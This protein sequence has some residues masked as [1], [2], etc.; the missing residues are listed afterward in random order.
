M[1]STTTTTM[2]ALRQHRQYEPLVVEEVAIPTAEPGSAV[3]EVL[4]AGVISYTRDVYDG[5]RKYPYVTPLT[6]GSSAIGRIHAVGPDSTKLQK[7]QLVL[8][9]IT[10]RSRDDSSHVFLSAIISGFTEGSRKLMQHWADGTYAE[11]VKAPLEN[12]FALDEARLMG[13][14]GYK[15]PDLL[16]MTRLL[17]PWG[18]LID[19]NLAPGETVVV[20]PATGSFG[21]GAVQLALAM[22]AR[23]IAMG[24]NARVLAQLREK[25]SEQYPADRL[26]TVPITGN[27]EEEM[28]A[29]KAAAGTRPIDA[30]YDISPDAATNATYFKAAIMSLRHSGRIS[31]MGG[32]RSEDVK[33]P[34]H[35]VMHWN[36]Q[37]KGKWMYEREDVPKFLRLVEAGNLS[38]GGRA[39][40]AAVKEFSLEQW[41][42]AFD[43]ASEH[44]SD[45]QG[46]CLVP[47]K[48]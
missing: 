29:L 39:G 16:S 6:T 30:F 44:A 36:L 28:T 37:L 18:G 22:G 17:V 46:T 32:Q 26:L 31:L 21:T 25:F 35:R 3:L 9:D 27:L 43:Y 38:L 23:V 11:Y 48:A 33:I 41:K 4:A 12:V 24:R 34:Y 45:G 14:L 7:G 19:I 8:F 42:E 1:T 5:T 2:K 40:A 10:V 20:A 15:I 13:E 47:A